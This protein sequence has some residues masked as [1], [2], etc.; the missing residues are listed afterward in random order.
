M[1]R[2]VVLSPGAG[3]AAVGGGYDLHVGPLA[4]VSPLEEVGETVGDALETVGAALTAAERRPR[5]IK[6]KLPVRGDRHVEADVSVAGQRMRRQVRQLLENPLWRMQGLYLWWRVDPEI[7]GWV[8]I[9][10]GDLTEADPG[11][12]FG[13][14]TLELSDL[15]VVGRPGTHRVGR[16]LDLADRRTA[17]VPRDTRGTLYA[18]DFSDHALPAAP[19]YLPGDVANAVSSGGAGVALTS[20]PLR[21]G[22]RLW[23]A[24]SAIDGE[25]VSYLADPAVFGGDVR[26]AYLTLDEVGSVRVYD[27]SRDPLYPRAVGDY[28]ELGD[29]APDAAGIGYGWER[30]FGDV[31]DPSAPLAIDNGVVR[32]VW[33]GAGP[34]AGLAFEWWDDGLGHYRREGRILHAAG[35]RELRAVEVT[36]ER[37]VVEIRAG[38]AALRVIVQR[39][40]HGCRLESYADDGGTARIEYAPTGGAPVVADADPVWTQTI[41][42][43]GRA[44]VWAQGAADEV[45]DDVIAAIGGPGVSYRRD[46]TIVAQIS[47]PAGPTSDEVAALSLVDAQSIPV[48]V[49]RR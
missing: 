20:G 3:A 14:F 33:L 49:G 40:W 24:A 35:A 1:T 16:R 34:E 17:V 11:V 48:L 41:T 43:D 2:F 38:D 45:H 19:L 27:V 6:L 12:A 37:A 30:V 29:G 9:G 22:R 25:V 4:F 10:G 47:S 5:P 23:R 15:Y 32:V 8:L 44:I 36:P 18:P 7:D 46:R 21:Y 42:A 28:D 39:G 26:D 13:E 31:L